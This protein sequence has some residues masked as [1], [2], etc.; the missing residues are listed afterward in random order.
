MGEKGLKEELVE[1]EEWKE[2]M[3]GPFLVLT[4]ESKKEKEEMARA[5]EKRNLTDGQTLP[6]VC[7]R[8]QKDF[9]W[10]T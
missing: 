4:V 10:I 1:G 7:R 6:T 2:A 9:T 3:M 8:L 5:K